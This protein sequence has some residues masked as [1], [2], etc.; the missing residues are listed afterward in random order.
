M[1]VCK[2]C[3]S[4]NLIEEYI[5]GD[6]VCGDCGI[7]IDTVIDQTAEW[8]NYSGKESKDRCTT[9][10]N[11]QILMSNCG[12]KKMQRN[13]VRATADDYAKRKLRKVK[14]TFEEICEES[15]IPLKYAQKA[16]KMYEEIFKKEKFDGGKQ[17]KRAKKLKGIKAACLYF[18]LQQSELPIHRKSPQE[19]SEITGVDIKNIN[20]AKKDIIEQLEMYDL[21]SNN[22]IYEDLVLKY[23]TEIK[24]YKKLTI[25]SSLISEMKKVLN[26]CIDN[27]LLLEKVPKSASVGCIWYI[28]S[29][30]TDYIN[31]KKITKRDIKETT[32]VS[33]VTVDNVVNI[34]KK[35]C[36]N[37]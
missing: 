24:H 19:I 6:I 7:V 8:R 13:L 15:G 25:H 22:N 31:T 37:K 28:L 29:T 26:E 27:G 35:H 1:E 36:Q 3:N 21:P 34:I 32:G 33:S 4:T 30:N 5:A 10:E 23:T 12:D 16:S 9:N 2:E 18:T 14:D 11:N 17:I 20:E